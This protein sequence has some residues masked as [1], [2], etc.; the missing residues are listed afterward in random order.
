[1]NLENYISFFWYISIITSSFDIFGNFHF[2]GNMR[3]CQIVLIVPFLYEMIL[4]FHKKRFIVPVGFRYLLMWSFFIIAFIAN[5]AFTQRSIIYA[6]WLITNILLVFFMV[7]YFQKQKNVYELLRVYIISFAIV[8]LFG[9]YQFFAPFLGLEP[10]LVTQWWVQGSLARINGFSY[11]PSYFSTYLLIGWIMNFYF[12]EEGIYLLKKEIMQLIYIIETLALILSSSRLGW[13]IMIL[14]YMENPC[15]ITFHLCRK[16]ICGYIERKL[17][18]KCLYVFL[19]LSLCGMIFVEF[20]DIDQFKFLLSG[21]GILENVASHS[22]DERMEAMQKTLKIFLNNPLIGVSLGGIAPSIADMQGI[23][24]RNIDDL[25]NSEGLGVFLEILAA[26]GI[27]G[28]IVFILYLKK[29]MNSFWNLHKKDKSKMNYIIKPLMVAF[30]GEIIALQFN[31]NILRT[32][33]W[34]HIAILSSIYHVSYRN[35]ESETKK[36][37][38]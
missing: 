32:Y 13:I 17:L 28:F 7:N 38:N 4:I 10:V 18:K 24:I 29:I 15:K 14:I 23:A 22:V 2:M 19:F 33:L 27:V 12:L 37:N 9:L 35:Q 25:K 1:M 3:I 30:W 8:A 36:F 26:S 6:L 34:I 11:E 31:Q 21:I 5:I 16:I 20:V